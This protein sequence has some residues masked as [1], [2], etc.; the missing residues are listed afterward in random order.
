MERVLEGNL[1]R[2]EVPDLLTFLNMGRRTGVLVMEHPEQETKLFFRA[3]NPV[4]A[5]STKEELR[6]GSMLVQSGRLQQAELEPLLARHHDGTHRLGQILLM[7]KVLK[8]DELA[9][10]LKVQVSEVIFDTFDWRAG[11]FSFYDDIPP[12]TSAVILEMDLQNLIM[13]G[14]RRI[15]ERGRL[16]EALPDLD[17]VVEAVANPERVK[18]SVTFTREEWQAFFLVDGRRTLREICRLVGNPDELAT[19]QIL[20]HLLAA[21]FITLVG[22]PVEKEDPG[23]SPPRPASKYPTQK[24]R[25]GKPTPPSD[26]SSVTFSPA[27]PARKQEDD[28]KDVVSRQAIRY[29]GDASQLTV[30]RLVLVKDGQESSFPLTRDSYTL[31]RHRNND[32]VVSD[33][34]VSGFHAR[35]DRSAEGFTLVDLNSRNGC[36]VNGR[37]VERRL[38]KTGDELRLGAARLKYRVDYTSDVT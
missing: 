18:Q 33:P 36:F 11:G 21:K 12:P 15:D 34:K 9:S 28:T 24:W 10:F 17:V 14:V 23:T 2:F 25:D 22:A 16:E 8:E 27:L 37:R 5:T 6:I 26:P 13:E 1:S 30:S 4:F 38:L 31:G 19:L 32:I 3:G 20:Q 7:E 35:I 29:M